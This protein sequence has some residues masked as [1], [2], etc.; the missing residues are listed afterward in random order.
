MTTEEDEKNT[1]SSL[2][3][4]NHNQ[5]NTNPLDLLGSS[6][7]DLNSEAEK[8]ANQ[9]A[10]AV[11]Q[12]LTDKVRQFNAVVKQGANSKTNPLKVSATAE[13]MRESLMQNLIEE[14]NEDLKSQEL[15][16][17]EVEKIQNRAEQRQKR[18]R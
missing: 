3:K 9:Q 2:E 5:A 10:L 4:N 7:K 6:D 13:D 17:K 8:I 16:I 11:K 18:K 1:D 14:K 12:A 15:I